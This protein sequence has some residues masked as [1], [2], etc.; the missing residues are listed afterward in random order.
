MLGADGRQRREATGLW[1]TVELLISVCASCHRVCTTVSFLS[2]DVYEPERGLWSVDVLKGKG[3]GSRVSSEKKASKCFDSSHT[4]RAN[5]FPSYLICDKRKKL[6]L[7][8]TLVVMR[9]EKKKHEVFDLFTYFS[10]HDCQ[11]FPHFAIVNKPIF[12]TA[13]RFERSLTEPPPTAIGLKGRFTQKKINPAWTGPQQTVKT[14]R[15][16]L[17]QTH[18]LLAVELHHST[19]NQSSRFLQHLNAV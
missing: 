6:I 18:N 19:L 3:Y 14:H 8:Y 9:K 1:E 15:Q 16:D 17:H 11:K 10:L 5:G 7:F 2:V 13:F 12:C 4:M